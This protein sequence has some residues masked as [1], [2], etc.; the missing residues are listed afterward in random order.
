MCK[1][2]SSVKSFSFVAFV[3]SV[4]FPNQQKSAQVF[5]KL[6]DQVILE[7]KIPSLFGGSQDI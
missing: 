3:C 1:T 7:V 4:H 5:H 2:L 6:I